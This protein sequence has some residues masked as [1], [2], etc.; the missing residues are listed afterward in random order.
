MA[1]IPAPSPVVLTAN[2]DSQLRFLDLRTV[3]Y[4]HEFRCTNASAGL[5]RCMAISSDSQWVAVGFS[6]GIMSLLNLKTGIMLGTWKA[7][8]GEIIQ[9]KAIS[10]NKFISCSYDQTVKVWNAD[11]IKDVFMLRGHTEPVHCISMYKNQVVTATTGNKIGVHSSPDEQ[12]SF[13]SGKLRSDTF[14]GV[15]TCMAVLPLNRTLLL[16]ADNG[17]IRLFC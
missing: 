10:K 12:G 14:K 5:I 7:H 9:M 2:T 4:T 6:S 15:L 11:D 13:T 17:S 3:G 8:E 1:A 16:G